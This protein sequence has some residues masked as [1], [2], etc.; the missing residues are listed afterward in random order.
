MIMTKF[1]KRGVPLIRNHETM[2]E[3]QFWSMF[4]NALR[5]LTMHWKPGHMYLRSIRRDS[6]SENK[7]Q[8]FEYPCEHCKQWFRVDEIELD[9]KAGC[10]SLNSWE[11]LAIWCERAFIEIDGGWSCLCCSCHQIKTNED[12]K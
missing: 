2:T 11:T 6:Q 4:R 10:G 8:K 12:R 7:R 5:K 3:A 9:H 1:S